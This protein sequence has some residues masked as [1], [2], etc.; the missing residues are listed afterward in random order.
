MNRKVTNGP[1]SSYNLLRVSVAGGSPSSCLLIGRQNIKGHLNTAC[2]LYASRIC[3]ISGLDRFFSPS[4]DRQS[5]LIERLHVFFLNHL[6]QCC[7]CKNNPTQFFDIYISPSTIGSI[8]RPEKQPSGI[9][10]V[11]C[12]FAALLFLLVKQLKSLLPPVTTLT[13]QY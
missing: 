13:T 4:I 2:T 7:T 11:S 8:E 6:S 12:V 1:S 10:N 9:R 3:Y 5:T